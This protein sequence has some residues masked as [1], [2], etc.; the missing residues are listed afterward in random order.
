MFVEWL[1]MHYVLFEILN[2]VS[3]KK[4]KFAV[5]K[6]SYLVIVFLIIVK[7]QKQKKH[8]K[9]HLL[10]PTSSQFF[11]TVY[12]RTYNECKWPFR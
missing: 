1:I 2:V 4:K 9:M 10:K 12:I 6:F 7:A 8:V 11:V 5:Y 3:Q